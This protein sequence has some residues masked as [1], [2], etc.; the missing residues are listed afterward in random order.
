MNEQDLPA[1]AARAK[2]PRPPRRGWRWTLLT[3]A[4]AFSVGVGVSTA[5]AQEENEEKKCSDTT[6]DNRPCTTTEELVFCVENSMDRYDECKAGGGLLNDL[7]CYSLYVVDFYACGAE[8]AL[9][10]LTKPLK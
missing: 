9:Y 4:L 8:S 1:A 3:V 7:A 2:K 5:R 10:L 6:P